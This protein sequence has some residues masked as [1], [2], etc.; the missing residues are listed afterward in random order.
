[1][2]DRPTR[3][4]LYSEVTLDHFLNPRNVGQVEGFEGIG[5]VKST[6]CQDLLEITVR[7]EAGGALVTG[8]RAQGCSACIAA[9]SALTEWVNVER[10]DERAA[11][12]VDAPALVRRLGGMPASKRACVAMAP[13]AMARALDALGGSPT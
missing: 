12:A 3:S 11:R 9:A 7:R 6:V 1:M 5:R 2:T 10:L 4:P 13:V 8:F